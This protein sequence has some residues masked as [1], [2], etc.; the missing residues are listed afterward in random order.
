M[1]AAVFTVI[2]TARPN[3]LQ[4]AL[5]RTDFTDVRCRGLL[6]AITS[7]R[8]AQCPA[9]ALT[10]AL[11][12]WRCTAGSTAVGVAQVCAPSSCDAVYEATNERI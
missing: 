11:Q 2:V 4:V 3:Y 8:R 7:T 10:A 9:A 12:G 5:D 6:P 1:V